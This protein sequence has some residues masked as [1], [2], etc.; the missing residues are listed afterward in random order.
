MPKDG[1]ES[2]RG[3][4]GRHSAC[5]VPVTVITVRSDRNTFNIPV[6]SSE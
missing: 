3:D 5:Q 2:A 4:S 1:M 6:G